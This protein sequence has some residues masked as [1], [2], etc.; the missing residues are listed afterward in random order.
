M[1]CQDNKS[2]GP[3]HWWVAVPLLLLLY[4]NY[5][6]VF[7]AGLGLT[8]TPGKCRGFLPHLRRVGEESGGEE[9]QEMFVKA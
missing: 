6:T 9:R 5:K 4:I 7:I 2:L 8:S 3:K 1:D